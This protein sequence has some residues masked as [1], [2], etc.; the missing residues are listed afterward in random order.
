MGTLWTYPA[1][2][3]SYQTWLACLLRSE[4][5]YQVEAGEDVEGSLSPVLEGPNSDVY[6]GLGEPGKQISCGPACPVPLTR[7]CSSTSS[8]A[9]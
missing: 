3:D 8:D 7:D 4:Y 9:K 2:G 6:G 1:A 5:R